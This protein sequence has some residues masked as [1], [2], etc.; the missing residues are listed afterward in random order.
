[1][2]VKTK[3]GKTIPLSS[4]IS[5]KSGYGSVRWYDIVKFIPEA[6]EIAMGWK[7]NLK[8]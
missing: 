2:L 8:V 1:M 3:D 5:T 6:E 7:E 4:S